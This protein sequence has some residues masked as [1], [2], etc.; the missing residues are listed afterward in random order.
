MSSYKGLGPKQQFWPIRMKLSK[1][2]HRQL[3]HYAENLLYELLSNIHRI[4]CPTPVC[5]T[6]I[7]PLTC[8][9]ISLAQFMFQAAVP[10]K[11]V[12]F[13]NHA[14]QYDVSLYH[15]THYA[16]CMFS[17]DAAP[18][19]FINVCFLDSDNGISQIFSISFNFCGNILF[20]EY[21]A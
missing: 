18:F 12:L 3:F 6:N 1:P 5:R 4:N 21:S 16:S 19:I 11:T 14:G 9:V 8:C 20:A 10:H 2:F 13:E 15:C 17:Y 7:R